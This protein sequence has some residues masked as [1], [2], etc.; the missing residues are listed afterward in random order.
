MDIRQNKGKGVVA[1]SLCP[2][3]SCG[4]VWAAADGGAL[5]ALSYWDFLTQF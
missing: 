3:G 2:G 1:D 5:S 4:F